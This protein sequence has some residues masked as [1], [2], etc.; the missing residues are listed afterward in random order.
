ME[1]CSTLRKKNPAMSTNMVGSR[2]HYV[3]GNKPDTEKQ[4]LH[5]ITYMLNLKLSFHFKKQGKTKTVDIN[6]PCFFSPIYETE[7]N[8]WCGIP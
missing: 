5:C 7:N 6:S 8:R 2:R 4:M 1:Y 3:T